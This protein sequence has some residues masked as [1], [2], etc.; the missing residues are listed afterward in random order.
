MH[1]APP[2]ADLS[3]FV[4]QRAT[5]PFCYNRTWLDLIAK[6]YRYPVVSLTTTDATGQVT[7]FLPVC[8]VR[9]PLTGRRVVALP[10]SD[11]CP[12]LASD[13]A[14]THS[15]VDQALALAHQE[16]AGY[17]ELRAGRDA[18]LAQRPDLVESNLYVRWLLPLSTDSDDLWARLKPPVQRQVKKA[19]K[20]GV[21]VRAA[22]SYE[23][24]AHYYRLHLHTRCRKHGMPAQ[25]RHFFFELWDAFG[26]SDTVRFLL[27]EAEGTVIAGMVLIASGSTVRYA[28]GASDERYLQLGP[29]NLLLWEAIVWACTHGYQT[30]DLGRTARDNTG[31]MAYKRGWGAAEEPLSYFYAPRVAGLAA[32]PEQSW[33]FHL[34]TACWKRLP[35]PV[36]GALGGV[37]Y[38]HLG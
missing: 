9:S 14:S 27:A 36:A 1:I 21:R 16:R 31:L 11:A 38:R 6:L 22:E 23:D 19:R 29:N 35:L 33:R 15:L 13:E 17:L 28:Y 4:A 8:T 34:L 3:T 24:V 5:T 30:L 25:P 18:V 26:P 7:G 32:T 37:L 10:F 2:K 20:L 12:P